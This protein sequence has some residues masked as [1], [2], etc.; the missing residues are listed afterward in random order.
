MTEQSQGAV[1]IRP[2]LFDSSS[3][4]DALWALLEPTFRAG[5]TYA[6]DADI[7]RADALAYWT[8]APRRAFM[9]EE[10][11]QVLGTYYVTPN[12][13]GGG[14]HVCNCGFVTGPAARGKGIARTMLAHAL[15][16]AKEIGFYAMQ[17]NFVVSTNTRAIDIWKRAG[18]DVVGTLPGAFN[19]PEAGLVDAYVMYKVL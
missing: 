12:Q 3:E 13:K 2:F 7:S 11:G 14:R 15:D 8:G 10:D 16:T 6:I 1:T 5:D 9:V 19:H 17:F 18:F 4:N